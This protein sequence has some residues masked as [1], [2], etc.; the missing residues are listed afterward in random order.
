MLNTFN[1]RL[2][3]GVRR[4]GLIIH[5]IVHEFG[6]N[7]PLIYPGRFK[8]ASNFAVAADRPSSPVPDNCAVGQFLM[9]EES[10]TLIPLGGVGRSAPYR[11]LHLILLLLALSIRLSDHGGHG[12]GSALIRKV[13]NLPIERLT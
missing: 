13:W 3:C 4:F 11:E 5:R 2:Y 7:V 9:A 1:Q 6:P 10:L 12:R 8:V